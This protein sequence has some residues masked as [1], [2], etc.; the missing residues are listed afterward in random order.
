MEFLLFII[1]LFIVLEIGG[2]KLGRFIGR[3][4]DKD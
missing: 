4:F 1:G 2:G 3:F